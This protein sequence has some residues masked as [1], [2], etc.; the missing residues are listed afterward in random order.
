MLITPTP[1]TK[2]PQGAQSD[3]AEQQRKAWEEIKAQQEQLKAEEKRLAQLQSNV[4]ERE[5]GLQRREQQLQKYEETLQTKVRMPTSYYEKEGIDPSVLLLS[6]C[7]TPCSR[8][9]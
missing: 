9:S 1:N 6:S 7:A 5:Q 3:T 8:C 2:C 4:K